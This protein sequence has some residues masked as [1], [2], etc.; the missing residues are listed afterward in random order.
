MA[1]SSPQLADLR[2]TYQLSD[3]TFNKRWTGQEGDEETQSYPY[4]CGKR[5]S[6]STKGGAITALGAA[7]IG[8]GP[9]AYPGDRKSRGITVYQFSKA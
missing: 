3:L 4:E 6:E 1:T 9:R 2:A 8:G 5:R 7:A